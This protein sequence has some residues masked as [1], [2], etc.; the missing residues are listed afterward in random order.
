[1]PLILKSS[2]PR[3]LFLTSG[4][5]TLGDSEN[6]AVPVN[7]SPK[8]AG[9]PKDPSNPLA[10][11]VP[12]Y[13]SVKTGLNMMMR[14]WVRVLKEDGVKCWSISPGMLATGLGVN[15]PERLR[16]MGALEPHIGAD[17]IR[18]VVEGKRD[19]DVGMA[20]RRDGVQPW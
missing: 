13:R 6:Q 16:T 10:M 20:I 3:I 8:D 15:D 18:D 7:K 14:E 12:A 4:T 19:G 11:G 17:F 1:M 5:A 2:N 9:W